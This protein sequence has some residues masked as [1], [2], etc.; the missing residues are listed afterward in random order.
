MPRAAVFFFPDRLDLDSCAS[1]AQGQGLLARPPPK[2]PTGLK[3]EAGAV[4][5]APPGTLV[6]YCSGQG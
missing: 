3:G 2:H 5:L 4:M 1:R 6:Y